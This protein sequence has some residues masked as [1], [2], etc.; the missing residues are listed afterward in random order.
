MSDTNDD[1][2]QLYEE[3][4]WKP[5][6]P[7]NEPY[8][9]LKFWLPGLILSI[10]VGMSSFSIIIFSGDMGWALFFGVPSA[11][12]ALLGF[13]VQTGII[14]TIILS[15]VSISAVV[16][17]LVSLDISGLFCGFTLGIIFVA[18]FAMGLAMGMLLRF[19]LKRFG[20]GQRSYLPT[21]LLALLPMGELGI[22]RLFDHPDELH[23]VSTSLT[24]HATSAKAWESMMFYEEV[25]VEPPWLLKLA[26]P[27]PVKAEGKMGQV[28]EVRRC[29]YENGYLSKRITK[30][31]ERKE[32]AFKVIEQKLHF[33]RDVTLKDGS[34][35]LN[36]MNENETKVVLTTR[37]IRHLRPAWLWR[38]IE[39]EV[40]HTLHQHVLEGMR[41]N[42]KKKSSP[43]PVYRPMEPNV[44]ATLVQSEKVMTERLPA[45]SR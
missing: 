33:E 32:L 34:F 31:V 25:N 13:R 9:R 39:E 18:P 16:V 5:K 43:P 29:I 45:E 12:G 28:G 35:L 19:L 36:R 4:D 20:W 27:R 38:P 26:L 37:Y 42:C 30:R 11:M 23:T 14:W 40:V 1:L 17:A 8:N 15:L 24:F 7:S 10:V 44:P 6:E 41:K 22:E 21:I 2:N 3:E